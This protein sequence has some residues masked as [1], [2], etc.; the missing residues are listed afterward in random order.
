MGTFIGIAVFLVLLVVV[1]LIL[2]IGAYNALVSLR[3]QVDRAWANIDVIL[4][5]RFEEIPQLIQVVEQYAQYERATID[6][7]ANARQRYGAARSTREK[8]GATQEISAALQGVVAIGEAYP[9]LKSNAKFLQLQSRISQL[10]SGI[11]DRR[12]GFN[13]AVTNYNTRIRQFPGLLFALLLGYD[14]QDLL[15]T[16]EAERRVLPNIK[17][18][19]V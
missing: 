8:V 7:V 15:R 12:E 14:R 4:K 18:N 9:E 17:M 11:A 10:E 3:N 16:T 1:T 19:L 2:V 13:E 5:Q 6:R